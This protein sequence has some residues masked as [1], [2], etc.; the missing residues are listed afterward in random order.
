M[1]IIP[2]K[3][4]KNNSGKRKKVSRK[5]NKTSS[6]KYRIVKALVK[7]GFKIFRLKPNVKTPVA[8]DW[9]KETALDASPWAN[10]SFL[11]SL[12]SVEQ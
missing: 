10:T 2:P 12:V 3:R 4:G 7:R 9:Q 8:K 1:N 5:V 6:R 11:G